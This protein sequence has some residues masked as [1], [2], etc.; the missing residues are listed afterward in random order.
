M[1]TLLFAA[2][3]V[4]SSLAAA[5]Q[6]QPFDTLIR[7]GRVVDGSGNPWV[8]ADVGIV[9]DRI[10]F[11]GHAA[12]DVKAKRTI[13]A[14]GLII[15]PGFIDMLGQSEL[16]LLIDKQAVSKLTQG[17]TT[18]ITGEGES[19]APQNDATIAAQKDFLD[20]YHLTIDWQ[21]LDEYFR[22]LEKQGSGINL[23]TYVG[24]A[25]LRRI[26]VGTENRPA[27]AAELKQMEEM[28]DDA[29]ND[30]ALGVSSALIYAP[31][32][33]ASTEELI[34]LAKVAA[35][36]MAGKKL[37]DMSLPLV[38]H[39]GVS[40]VAVHEF[41]SVKSPV[42][43]FNKFRGVDTI[44]GPEMRSTG[45][46]M[47]ISSSYGQAFAKAQLAA[48]QRLPRKGSRRSSIHSARPRSLVSPPSGSTSEIVSARS[49]TCS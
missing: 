38:R 18:E 16:T 23:G 7:N 22:R 24:A 4:L 31:G 46:V 12:P 37:A 42:F 30:G 26:A 8:Y 45:E 48:G 29:M 1:K 10:A 36:L 28:V 35:R 2:V 34:A 40:E 39:G 19:V 43:P 49:P 9:G 32:N 27:T 41:Y 47:G 33:Y 14:T 3:L 15:A 13:D 25:Q 11:V 21:S 17:I 5:Q 44:L 6:Q 20:H